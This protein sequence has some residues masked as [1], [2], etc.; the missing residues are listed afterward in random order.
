MNWRPTKVTKR[1]WKRIQEEG[2]VRVISPAGS[3]LKRYVDHSGRVYHSKTIACLIRHGLIRP[4]G[5]TMGFTAV[6]DSQT[7][8][9]AL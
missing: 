1:A 2:T 3:R 4:S 7:M 9:V 6:E 8:E 5:D